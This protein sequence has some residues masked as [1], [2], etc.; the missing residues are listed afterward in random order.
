MKKLRSI[1]LTL[2]FALALAACGTSNPNADSPAAGDETVQPA[3]GTT[4]P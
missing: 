2:L 4:T 1:T 3:Q